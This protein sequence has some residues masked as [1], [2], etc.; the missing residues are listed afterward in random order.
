MLADSHKFREDF[1]FVDPPV[2]YSNAGGLHRGRLSNQ[3]ARCRPWVVS[4]KVPNLVNFI[5]W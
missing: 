3:T 4:K 5:L 2:L 1:G